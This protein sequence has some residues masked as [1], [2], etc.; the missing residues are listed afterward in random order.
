MKN[1]MLLL[2]TLITL[3]S[4]SSCSNNKEITCED[5]IKIYEE[6]GYSVFHSKQADQED[7]D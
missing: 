7:V 6:A 2:T 3:A 4:L 1:K 5:V